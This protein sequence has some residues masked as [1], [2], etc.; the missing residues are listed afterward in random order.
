M[1]ALVMALITMVVIQ[2][3]AQAQASD[4]VPNQFG[5]FVM[6]LS[7]SQVNKRL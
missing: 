3:Q 2:S 6:D 1:K 5:L 7:I 4:F